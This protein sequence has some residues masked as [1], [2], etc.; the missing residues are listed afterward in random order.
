MRQKSA[1]QLGNTCELAGTRLSNLA[2][3][4]HGIYTPPGSGRVYSVGSSGYKLVL[5]ATDECG[6]AAD[7]SDNSAL[8][9]A[10]GDLQSGISDL[11]SA[12]SLVAPWHSAKS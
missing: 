11:Y 12:E 6:I 3:T 8:K 4:F 7:G 10:A 9:T 2:A 5:A 1:S